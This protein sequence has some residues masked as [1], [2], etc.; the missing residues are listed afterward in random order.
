MWT[1]PA[2]EYINRSQAHEYGN[3]DWGRTI[4]K[5]YINGIFVA[6]YWVSV[7]PRNDGTSLTL[8]K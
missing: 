8:A 5:E 7:Y 6:V 4:E 1:D 2:W 3:W